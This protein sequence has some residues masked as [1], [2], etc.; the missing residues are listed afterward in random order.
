MIIAVST[1]WENLQSLS[2]ICIS[3]VWKA[4]I[5]G[6]KLGE[7]KLAV[8]VA[9]KDSVPSINSSEFSKKE[10]VI[11]CVGGS[12]DNRITDTPAIPRE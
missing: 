10:N 9:R 2:V 12:K 11:L 8:E 6:W 5:G 3:V 7:S 1:N 4:V